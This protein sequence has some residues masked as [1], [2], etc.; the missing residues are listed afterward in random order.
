MR[1]RNKITTVASKLMPHD[2]TRTTTQLKNAVKTG[3][4]N[5]RMQSRA[6]NKGLAGD[7]YTCSK[8]IAKEFKNLKFT[9]D[10]IP[11]VA[12]A[13]GYIAPIPIPGLTI[14]AYAAGVGI[15]KLLNLK[16]LILAG[17]K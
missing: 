3:W 9:K 1:V 6:N 11:A 2:L 14:Y 16:N 8:C 4:Q 17:R 7:V 15:K 12:A 10:D 13:I 5:G